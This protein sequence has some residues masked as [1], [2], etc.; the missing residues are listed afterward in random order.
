MAP[1]EKATHLP[2]T[3][4]HHILMDVWWFPTISQVKV[5]NHLIETTTLK[6]MFRVPGGWYTFN[7]KK[8][9]KKLV[10]KLGG[11]FPQLFGVK[12]TKHGKTHHHRQ[13]SASW[14]IQQLVVHPISP[15]STSTWTAGHL[16]PVMRFLAR[17]SSSTVFFFFPAILPTKVRCHC[18]IVR[19]MKSWFKH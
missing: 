1:P 17:D 16:G 10:K 2:G 15:T 5:W 13:R 19:Y 4:N 14:R 18:V 11:I 9:T 12:K 6:G 3:L 8:T 7:L